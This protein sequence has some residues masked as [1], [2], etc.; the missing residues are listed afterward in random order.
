MKRWTWKKLLTTGAIAAALVMTSI[1][2]A[3][4]CTTI[5]VG[6]NRVEEGTPF[7]AR[8]EDYGSDMNKLW[9]ICEAGKWKA[10]ETYTSCP[11]YGAMEWTFTHD[12][13]RFTHFTND[14]YYDGICPECGENVLSGEPGAFHFSYTEFGTNEKGVSV[15]ATETIGGNEAVKAVDPNVKTG[16]KGGG[17]EETDIPTILLAE[18]ATAREGVE[19]LC[20][21]YDTYGAYYDSG[22][23]ICDQNE[24]WYIENCSGTQYIALKLNDDLIFIEPNIAIIG[25][26]DLD[27]TENVIASPRLIEVAKQAGTFVGNEEENIID[28]KASY[29]TNSS[30]NARMPDGLKFLNPEQYADVDSNYL[31]EHNELFTLSNVKDGQIVPLYS[32]IEADRVLD[33]N[34]IFD[35]YKLSSIGK[36]SN[37]EIEIFQLFRDNPVETG[38][39][40]WVGVGNMSNNVF[41]PYYPMLLTDQYEGYQ[42]STPVV[43]QSDTRP[44]GFCT[45]TTRNDGKFVVYPQ[46]WRDS[47]YFTFEGLG[48]YILYAEQITGQ[49]VSDAD[50]QYVLDQLDALQ[51]EINTQ[52]AAM[53]PKDTTKVGMEMA[54]KAHKKGL[55]L[56]DYLLE[57]A[58]SFLDV[59]SSAWYYNAVEFVNEK[60]LLNGIGGGQFG[61]NITLTRAMT[62]Q[63]LYS[64]AGKPAVS[65]ADRGTPYTDVPEDAWYADAVYWSRQKGIVSGVSEDQ[66]APDAPITREQLAV[67]LYNYA[68]KPNVPN[69]ALLF[70]DREDVSGFADYAIRWSVDQGILGGTDDNRLLP[71]GCAT[72]GEAAQMIMNFYTLLHT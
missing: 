7:V 1:I 66:Y 62:A 56:I 38:T 5:Y 23:F 58:P 49:P 71:Q 33:K 63:I 24:V 43:T 65:Q 25:A 9:F 44:D 21:I 6:G 45:W 17:I 8:T 41:V 10:G 34:D 19:L 35:F 40:G 68:G 26:I 64:M 36:P 13:Y 27:D 3:S 57:K 67:M 14:I 52:F 72:R 2:G 15:S 70:A 48:G 31:N 30:G 55:E 37:Q 61:P 60:S 51:M 28:F 46:N 22:L 50:K 18:A 11:A 29:A 54:E 69:L 16:E 53:D 42:V 47:Y 59:P 20:E 12:S 4:A 32:N 39:V